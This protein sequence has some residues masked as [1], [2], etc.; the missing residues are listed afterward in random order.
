MSHGYKGVYAFKFT[1][2]YDSLTTIKFYDQS[3]GFPSSVG[4]NV[5]QINGENIFTTIEGAY[6]Y[7]HTEPIRSLLIN[8]SMRFWVQ[9]LI[10]NIYW[11]IISVTF[12]L[13][14]RNIL[15]C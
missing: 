8:R 14:A 7:D 2:A 11:R 12:S 3:N 15:E 5:F 6:R 10:L 13:S 9:K 4:M 1:E